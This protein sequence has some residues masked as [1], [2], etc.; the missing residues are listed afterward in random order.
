MFYGPGYAYYGPG[1]GYYGPPPPPPLYGPVLYPRPVFYGPRYPLPYFR[2][3]IFGPRH[4]R[5]CSIF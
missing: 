2:P 1:Y 3:P 5:G 4:H